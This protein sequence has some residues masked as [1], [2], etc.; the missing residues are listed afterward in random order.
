MLY[1]LIIGGEIRESNT[2][3]DFL[4]DKVDAEMEGFV[5]AASDWN[6]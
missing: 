4:Q 5:V 3:F 2:D 6:Q 1:H